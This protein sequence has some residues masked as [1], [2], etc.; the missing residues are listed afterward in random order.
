VTGPQMVVGTESARAGFA[1]S[2]PQ[3]VVGTEYTGADSPG[4][5]GGVDGVDPG[6]GAAEPAEPA[7]AADPGRTEIS[8]PTGEPGS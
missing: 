5:T 2:G 6:R 4:A 8:R 7:D 1:A 3:E